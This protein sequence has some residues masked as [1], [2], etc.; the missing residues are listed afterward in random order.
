MN[1][2][3]LPNGEQPLRGGM[4]IV[5]ALV[6]ALA[7]FIAV[8]DMT[9]ANVS[10]A[11]I[12]GSLGVTS[13]QG[14][15][16][17]TSYAVAEAIT[18]PLTGWLAGRFGAVRVFVTSMALFGLASLLCGF[19]NS[20]GML[21]GARVL[22]GLAGGP[23]MPLSQTLLLRIFPKDKAAAATA[24][25]A[26]T[27]LV[28]PILGP[29]VGGVICDQSH[30]S[31]IFYINVPIA[32]ICAWFGWGLLK[33]YE[34]GLEKAPIDKIGLALLIIWV[35]ALQIMLDEGKNLDWFSS[36]LIVG[37]A[38]VAVIGFAAFLIWELNERHPIVDLRVF[39][40]R[41]YSFG[42]LTLV[43]AF[44]AFF[45]ANVLTPLWLQQHMGYTATWSG[46]A[47]AWS[48]VLAVLC[49]PF[50]AMLSSKID[51]RPLVFFG[52]SW[53]GAVTLWR[54]F[55]TTDMTY[56]QVALPLLVMG[57]G[58]PFFF[59][60]LTG[61]ILGSVEERETASAAGLMNFLRTLAGA[62]ATSLTTASWEDR[63]QFNRADMVA[64]LDP[65][66]QAGV[67]SQLDP[68]G[69]AAHALQDPGTLGSLERLVEG[70]SVMLAT[71]QLFML[72]AVILF[73]AACSI[74]LAPRATRAVDPS[75]SH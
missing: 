13:S 18:V 48:G 65:V 61:Q 55:G 26:M 1:Q 17:I 11:T 52:V 45:G 6:L 3:L 2:A 35:G 23:L 59:V 64:T 21:V 15:W 14:T 25:W 75:A 32:L 27:T 47:T 43:L 71:N 54:A 22:Q 70:Q 56:W 12:A 49:A 9:I 19:S 42:V 5:G 28:A 41:G 4:L 30:W 7:N 57:I 50:A 66:N 46:M 39:R 24:I 63:I 68:L 8:L 69:S 44:G 38:I 72:I 16:V 53:L 31:W 34:T 60:P 62:F 73:V 51:S 20:L 29:I 58:M 67:A 36:P 40:H 37:L 74:W 10:V 33:R